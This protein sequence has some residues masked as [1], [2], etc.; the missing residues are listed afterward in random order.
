MSRNLAVR[1]FGLR[2]AWAALTWLVAA[3]SLP[4]FAAPTFDYAN[5]RPYEARIPA[6]TNTVGFGT[7]G[8]FAV[9]VDANGTAQVYDISDPTQPRL[10][11]SRFV[12][13]RI[14]H[15][16]MSGRML[17][18][19][20]SQNSW[21]GDVTAIFELWD[22]GTLR[23]MAWGYLQEPGGH[24]YAPRGLATW[25]DLC[26]YG[27]YRSFGVYPNIF[28]SR[29]T[30]SGFVGVGLVQGPGW[31]VAMAMKDNRLFV[32]SE[33]IGIAWFDFSLEGAVTNSG[34]L[35]I[36][37][38]CRAMDIAGDLLAVMER[39]GTLNL[40]D[41][42][43]GGLPVIISRTAVGGASITLEVCDKE[44]LLADANLGIRRVDIADRLA[45][46]LTD[47]LFTTAGATGVATAGRFVL[48]ASRR[49]GVEI[50]DPGVDYGGPRRIFVPWVT[51]PFARRGSIIFGAGVVDGQKSAVL[52]DIS[53]AGQPRLVGSATQ[54]WD[55]D[56]C[57]DMSDGLA[58]LAC[59]YCGGGG[60]VFYSWDA[61]RGFTSSVDVG[62]PYLCGA[63]LG[64][65]IYLGSRYGTAGG[66]VIY[67]FDAQNM[68]A[69]RLVRSFATERWPRA[70]SING[71]VMWCPGDNGTNS[72][73]FAYD[74]AD[75]VNPMIRGTTKLPYGAQGISVAG[76]V[77]LA[78]GTSWVDVAPMLYDIS[79]PNQVT[80]L[81]ELPNYGGVVS[82]ALDGEFAYLG[83]HDGL[84][85]YSISDPREPRLLGAAAGPML[86]VDLGDDMVLASGSGGLVGLPRQSSALASA[87]P[88]G[89]AG[90]SELEA[91]P[92]PFNPRI[93]V[94]LDLERGG[95]VTVEVFDMRGRRVARLMQ[96]DLPTGPLAVSWD[97]RDEAGA[98][99]TSGS[100]VIRAATPDGAVARKVT[101]VR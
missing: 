10:S 30:A 64:T 51:G 101:L 90:G 87:V 48:A 76:D 52:V 60:S 40:V 46:C 89:H 29:V 80:A 15:V 91:W 81:S 33:D 82:S 6:I 21:D 31:P 9:L 85:V 73:L 35:G 72:L 88:P 59:K 14:D 77:M 55:D 11:S 12:V 65:T 49:D 79:R 43:T 84:A 66:G 27:G 1:R 24:Y 58:I 68:P 93:S 18:V 13:S 96:A 53:N 95:P 92:N 78:S 45:P 23:P 5:Y 83:T 97:G 2:G 26:F 70:L 57:V 16:A 54:W 50:V 34:N 71:N 36:G 61:E 28:I 25:G 62:G 47:T 63:I 56:M 86:H 41:P 19:G 37:A 38:N 42:G 22:D 32:S 98:P 17:L 67:V 4:A 99:V 3:C 100:Y 7:W 8:H 94:A 75:P 44:V 74:V 20:G 69:L 39:D